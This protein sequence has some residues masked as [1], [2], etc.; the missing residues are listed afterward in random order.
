MQ[1]RRARDGPA[2]SP[3]SETHQRG[4]AVRPVSVPPPPEKP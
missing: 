3:L 2:L 1:A 4:T